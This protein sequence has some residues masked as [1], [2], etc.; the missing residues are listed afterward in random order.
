MSLKA[1]LDCN[2]VLYSTFATDLHIQTLCVSQSL[3]TGR[4]I[5]SLKIGYFLQFL[6]VE[7]RL[8]LLQIISAQSSSA[9]LNFGLPTFC[10]YLFSRTYLPSVKIRRQDPEFG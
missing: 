4:R 10:S 5:R 6:T 7:N 1:C 8:Q 3:S 2:E 9:T